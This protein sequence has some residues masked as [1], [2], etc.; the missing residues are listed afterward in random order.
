MKKIT[1][2]ELVN[3]LCEIDYIDSET[4]PIIFSVNKEKYQAGIGDYLAIP[5]ED[6]EKEDYS[7]QSLNELQIANKYFQYQSDEML[8]IGGADEFNDCENPYP[9]LFVDDPD[10][11]S[12][13]EIKHWVKKICNIK[14]I[15]NTEIYLDEE[16]SFSGTRISMFFDEFS[17]DMLKLMKEIVEETE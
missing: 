13:D 9:I 7:Q 11:I 1:F 5:I 3:L 8:Y 16:N 2:K 4:Y 6:L 12:C 10:S 17:D 15:K 14:T